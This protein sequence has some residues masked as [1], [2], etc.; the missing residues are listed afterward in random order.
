VV[1]ILEAADESL[2][3]RSEIIFP[4][5]RH[6]TGGCDPLPLRPVSSLRE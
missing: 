2:K 1:R 4:S 5:S 6:S 3:R